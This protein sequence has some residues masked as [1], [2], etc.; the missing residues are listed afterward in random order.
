MLLNESSDEDVFTDH[1]TSYTIASD[2]SEIKSSRLSGEFL[3][4][5][6][7]NSGHWYST[8]KYRK[9]TESQFSCSMPYLECSDQIVAIKDSVSHENASQMKKMK[10]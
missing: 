9:V 4:P 2:S 1:M 5:S 7:V 6:Q 8:T 10:K 3:K